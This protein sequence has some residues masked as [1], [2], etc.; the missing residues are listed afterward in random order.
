M[1]G[2]KIFIS[3]AVFF[4]LIALAHAAASDRLTLELTAVKNRH[5]L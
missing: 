1:M 2:K 4:I 5:R 3:M